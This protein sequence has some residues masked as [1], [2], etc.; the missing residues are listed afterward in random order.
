MSDAPLSDG[1]VSGGA[2][3]GAVDGVTA[4]VPA[5]NEAERVG[6]TVR[7]LRG[8]GLTVIVVD[9]ASTDGTARIATAEGAHVIALA[10]RMGKGGA[11]AAGI[12]Q[13][14]TPVCVLI[15][16]DLATTATIATSLAARV[17]S[18]DADLIVAAP[19]REGASGFGLV[20][21]FAR[22][23]VAMLCRRTFDRPLSGQRA[24]RTELLRDV[25]IAPGFGVEVAMSIDAVRLGYRVE[26]MP[27]AFT[28][29]KTTRDAAGFAHRIRQ[30]AHI[31]RAL[32][33]C[34][35]RPRRRVTKE[36]SWQPSS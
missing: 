36:G 34:A 27:V 22:A 1:T 24:A 16:A 21:R 15:D 26:E 30:G 12:A 35:V 31:A 14:T 4:I 19:P 10:S 23:G 5:R 9:D 13:A 20:E 8:A 28:H 32:A 18:G 11:L 29:A 6:A 2:V 7:A 33:W 17:V 3:S 25:R